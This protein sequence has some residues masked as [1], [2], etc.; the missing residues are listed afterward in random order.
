MKVNDTEASDDVAEAL[1]VITVLDTTAITD[2]PVEMPVPVTCIPSEMDEVEVST[3]DVEPEVTIDPAFVTVV[4]EVT[5]IPVGAVVGAALGAALGFGVGKPG[6]YV[7]IL[8][9]ETVGATVGL[10]DGIGVGLLG[11]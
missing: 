9:G 8:V 1:N 4:V 7:G 6:M 2:V 10:N 3:T 11:K 5:G